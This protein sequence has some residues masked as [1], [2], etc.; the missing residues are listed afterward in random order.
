MTIRF[1]LYQSNWYESIHQAS[2]T[3]HRYVRR[4]SLFGPLVGREKMLIKKV[5][6]QKRRIIDGLIQT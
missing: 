6:Q 4:S 2:P 3:V 1:H 5:S